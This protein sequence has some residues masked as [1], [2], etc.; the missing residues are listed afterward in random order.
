MSQLLDTISDIT[1]GAFGE[2]RKTVA[3]VSTAMF[4][5]SGLLRSFAIDK[6]D[7]FQER[8]I[9]PL[10]DGGQALVQKYMSYAYYVS[11]RLSW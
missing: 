11:A 8:W 4:N 9:S 3:D 7:G 5:V 6:V 10:P 1:G 2:A